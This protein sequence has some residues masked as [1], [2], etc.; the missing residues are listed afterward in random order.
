MEVT[1]LVD[2]IPPD[3]V[4]DE[5]LVRDES[6]SRRAQARAEMLLE[7]LPARLT[8]TRGVAALV[9]EIAD[10]LAPSAKHVLVAAAWLHDI[11]YADAIG[12]RTGF[13]PIDGAAWARAGLYS[14]VIVGLIAHHSG[15]WSE[16]IERGLEA[17]L[18]A[19]PV[20]PQSFLDILTY[21]DLHT[22]PHGQYLSVH[23]RLRDI[24]Q[25][26]AP[27]HQVHRAIT[28]STRELLRAVGRVERDLRQRGHAA[29][30]RGKEAR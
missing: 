7:H 2:I 29:S 13:H 25:R 21:A 19:F 1:V 24:L 20:P 4:R 9:G 3:L 23:D 27:D 17:E 26:Y 16:A 11:G 18:Q 30:N 28:R 10:V 5:R 8:H 14:D 6:L 15:A 22:G 12:K